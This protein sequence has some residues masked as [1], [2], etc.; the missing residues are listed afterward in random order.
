MSHVSGLGDWIT[1]PLNETGTAG[2]RTHL[3]GKMT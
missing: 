1:V 3:S 2:G